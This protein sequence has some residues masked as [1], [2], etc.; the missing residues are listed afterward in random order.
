MDINDLKRNSAAAAEGQWISDIPDLGDVRL[1]VRGLSSPKVIALRSR[2]ERAVPRKERLRDGSLAP[3]AAI[4]I[5]GEVLHEAV[6]LDWDGITSGGKPVKY[7]PKLAA[8]WCTNPDFSDFANAVAWAAL[9][10][11]RGKAEETGDLAGN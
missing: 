2:K 9:V 10:V 8:E 11:D 7:D 5:S 3:E 1:R 4:L 6:L